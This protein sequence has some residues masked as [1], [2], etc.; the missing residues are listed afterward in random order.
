MF[1][2]IVQIAIEM[3]KVRFVIGKLKKIFLIK[4]Y[5]FRLGF[6]FS[7]ENLIHH[8]RHFEYCLKICT[9]CLLSL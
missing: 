4:I 2:D 3:F 9:V 1:L 7:K 6:F 8:F 5:D